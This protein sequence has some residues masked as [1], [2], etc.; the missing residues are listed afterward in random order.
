M[1]DG[2]GFIHIVDRIKEMIKVKGQ[3]V[4][5]A[6]L[7]S[8]LLGHVSIADCAVV[9]VPD[10]ASGERP[11]AYVVLKPGIEPSDATGRDIL[12]YVKERRVRYKWIREVEFIAE[13]P[14]SPS[15]KILR[16]VLREKD[17]AGDKGFSVQDAP[18]RARL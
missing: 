1:V 15:S 6:E 18:E 12:R 17:R 14:K 4:A 13:I 5:P 7:E 3:Q 8:L 11:K 10:S 9:G 2:D 16:R